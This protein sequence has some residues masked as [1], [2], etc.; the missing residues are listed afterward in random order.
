MKKLP[1]DYAAC[2]VE[3]MRRRDDMVAIA[4]SQLP[5]LVSFVI[6]RNHEINSFS[7]RLG[8]FYSFNCPYQ[9]G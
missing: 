7:P 8:C 3:A 6:V 9:S 2:R 1:A 4:K 5:L